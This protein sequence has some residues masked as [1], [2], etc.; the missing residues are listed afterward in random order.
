MDPAPRRSKVEAPADT[1]ATTP[2]KPSPP[3]APKQ[4]TA[5][6]YR[7]ETPGTPLPAATVAAA[8]GPTADRPAASPTALD[9]PFVQAGIF[10]VPANAEKLLARLRADGIAAEGKVLARGGRQL[11]RVVAGPFGTRTERDEAQRRIRA[12]GLKDAV[13]VRR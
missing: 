12:M 4:P 10:G 6:G 7:W 5:S 9:K 2:A 8:P 11:T 3:P 13:P 1:A